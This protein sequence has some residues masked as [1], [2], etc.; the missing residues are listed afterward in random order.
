MP[1]LELAGQINTRLPSYFY[2]IPKLI[3]IF[4][5]ETQK[6]A[7]G[8]RAPGKGLSTQTIKLQTIIPARYIH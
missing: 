3:L 6:R 4:D 2:L 5:D 8:A 1:S 7:Q